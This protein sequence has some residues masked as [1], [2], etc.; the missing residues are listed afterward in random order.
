MNEDDILKDDEIE[1]V[2]DIEDVENEDLELDEN[3]KKKKDLIDEDAVS[4]EDEA[5]EELGEEDE[6]FDDVTNY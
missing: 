2:E 4:L 3:G 6:P 1:G 5:E